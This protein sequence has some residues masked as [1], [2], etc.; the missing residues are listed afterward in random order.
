MA[1][2]ETNTGGQK[3]RRECEMF[4]RLCVYQQLVADVRAGVLRAVPG[5]DVD[6]SPVCRDG[7]DVELSLIHI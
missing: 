3:G 2:G 6:C 5:A 1:S 7:R 4:E